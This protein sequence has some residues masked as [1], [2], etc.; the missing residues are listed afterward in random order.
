MGTQGYTVPVKNVTLNV[1][2]DYYPSF[3]VSVHGPNHPSSLGGRLSNGI[4]PWPRPA[5]TKKKPILEG[6]K[7]VAIDISP[8]IDPHLVYDGM[9][10]ETR[11]HALV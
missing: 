1:L 4:E 10:P 9:V 8:V 6:P 3:V 5:A 2:A 11:I 7:L